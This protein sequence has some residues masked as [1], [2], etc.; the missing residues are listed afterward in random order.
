MY[1]YIQS[2]KNN[3]LKDWLHIYVRLQETTV[4][5]SWRLPGYSQP[6]AGSKS[7]GFSDHR[8]WTVLSTA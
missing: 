5:T 3:R 8:L 6:D 2:K 4:D 7:T 1:F